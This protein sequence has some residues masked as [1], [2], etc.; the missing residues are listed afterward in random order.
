MDAIYTLVA[1]FVIVWNALMI[2][3]AIS[4]FLARRQTRRD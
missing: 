3:R 4:E 1:I 2:E